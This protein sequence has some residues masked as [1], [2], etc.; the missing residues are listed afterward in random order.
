MVTRFGA[1]RVLVLPILVFNAARNR[2][3]VTRIQI[4]LPKLFHNNF[5]DR[6]ASTYVPPNPQPFKP[7][8]LQIDPSL[9]TPVDLSNLIKNSTYLL[10]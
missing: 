2:G 6:T 10:L 4:I 9:T 8:K 3:Q 1:V 7:V 5:V